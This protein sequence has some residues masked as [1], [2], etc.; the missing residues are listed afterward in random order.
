MVFFGFQEYHQIVQEFQAGMYDRKKGMV[1]IE[2]ADLSSMQVEVELYV[3][4][5]DF[6]KLCSLMEKVWSPTDFLKSPCYEPIMKACAQAEEA[7]E[8]E[9]HEDVV[10]KA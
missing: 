2:L 8:L 3:W 5:D 4:N 1:E 7:L 9:T 10:P 6:Y